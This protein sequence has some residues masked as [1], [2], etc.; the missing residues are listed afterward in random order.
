[1]QMGIIMVLKQTW[2]N[3]MELG[4]PCV[5]CHGHNDG[6]AVS[7]RVCETLPSP[8]A[9]P[10]LV[11][12][13]EAEEGARPQRQVPLPAVGE[14]LPPAADERLRPVRRVPGDE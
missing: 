2:N 11:D 3:F 5:A 10:E 8:Q 7:E 1:M 14:G 6:T 12:A 13:A 9:H 4:C